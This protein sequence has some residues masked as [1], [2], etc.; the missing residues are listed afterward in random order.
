MRCRLRR[1]SETWVTLQLMKKASFPLPKLRERMLQVRQ[2]AILDVVNQLLADK[3]Y[4]LMTMDEVAATVGIAKMSLYRHF[5]SKEALA[6]AAMVRLLTHVTALLDDINAAS[7]PQPPLYKLRAVVRWALQTQYDGH[8]PSLPSQ[9]SSL[10]AALACD[11]VYMGLLDGVSEQL[12]QWIDQAKLEGDL[13]PTL[14][15]ELVLFTLFARAC[16]PVLG[17]LKATGS[18]TAPQIFEL[19]LATCFDGLAARHE[20]SSSQAPHSKNK[21]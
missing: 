13:A 2:E 15:T 10:A 19:L 17:I 12:A 5:A 4:D 21:M 18:Y 11:S 7:P 16:D 8:M 20:L 6:A 1:L 9:R 3:G 14:P